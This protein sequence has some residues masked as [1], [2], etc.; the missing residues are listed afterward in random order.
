MK[1]NLKLLIKFPTRGRPEKFFS[2]LDK[3]IEMS[4][5][6]SNIAFLISMDSDDSTMN[7]SS[8]ISKLENY[9]NRIK[10]AYFFGDSKTKIQACNADVDKIIGWDVVLLA[11]DDMIPVEKGYD[12]IITGDMNDHFKNLDGVLWYNDGG[13]N[14][15]NTLCILGKKYYERF[16]YI[17]HPDY[18]S[19]WCDNEF[20]DV[21]LNLKKCYRS[22]RII[23]EHA[24]PVYQK[25]NYDQLYVRNESYFL[26]DKETYN[27]RK[28]KNFDLH[29][30]NK[31]LFSILILGIPER[32]DK[33]KYLIEKLQNQIEKY[34]VK[35][36]VEILV[37][38]DNKTRS[39]GNKRQSILNMSEGRFV[40]YIDD[41]DDI[42][43]DY[44]GEIV[45]A[46]QTNMDVDVISFNQETRINDDV[47]T[48]V[49]FGLQ[50]ENTEYYQGIPVYRKPF[51][52]CVWNSKIAKETEFNDISLTEDWCWVESLCK[53]AKTE[54]HIDKILHYYLFNSNQTTSIV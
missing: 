8:V 52:M 46:I 3:Y 28:E 36:E 31:K 33:L 1:S 35:S 13:Q 18:I 54:H 11:S 41:D 32:M 38:I 34:K 22:D 53:L 26:A 50:Y 27:K 7:N 20:T 47:P 2:V 14:N 39:V 43:D 25:T 5:N 40:A 16:D 45:N 42:S 21:S 12:T 24:H 19:L 49:H 29:N 48:I 9:K 30:L 23:I 10:L 51:H 6:V 37:I 17:Y 44:I 15:I 4:E